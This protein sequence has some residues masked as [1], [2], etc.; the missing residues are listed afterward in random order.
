MGGEALPNAF[1]LLPDLRNHSA[2]CIFIDFPGVLEF[3]H[4]GLTR[5][6]EPLQMQTINSEDL[7]WYLIHIKLSMVAQRKQINDE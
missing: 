2:L 6:R 7:D 5:F 1:E 3:Y 4:F